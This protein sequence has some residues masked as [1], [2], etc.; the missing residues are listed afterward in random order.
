[1]NFPGKVY[2]I[3]IMKI[4]LISVCDMWEKLKEF[5]Y[6]SVWNDDNVFESVG[7]EEFVDDVNEMYVEKEG[8]GG[9]YLSD[10]ENVMEFGVNSKSGDYLE[11]E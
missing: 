3:L 5:N 11:R 4:E 2:I 10:F 8:K 6:M 1:L 9:W 7:M